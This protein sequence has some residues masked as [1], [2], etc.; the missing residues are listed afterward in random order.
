V[1]QNGCALWHASPELK[2]NLDVVTAAVAQNA[3]AVVYVSPE[4]MTK[5]ESMLSIVQHGGSMY[6]A[7]AEFKANP[8]LVL[9]AVSQNWRALKHASAELKANPEVVIAAVAQNIDA[10]QHAS[11]D[12]HLGGLRKRVDAL[13][14]ARHGFI[15]AFLV[16]SRDPQSTL[17]QLFGRNH[18]DNFKRLIAEYAGVPVGAHGFHVERAARNL[19]V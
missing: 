19:G 16:G 8:E 13:Q 12:L 5:T 7:S 17:V 14:C 2:A 9:A 15:E 1:A 6:F 4:L 10:L 3:Q 11:G 18:G